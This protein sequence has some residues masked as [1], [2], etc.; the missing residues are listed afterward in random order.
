MAGIPYSD[1]D[2]ELATLGALLT[3]SKDRLVEW[4]DKLTED[5]FTRPQYKIIYRAVM[6]VYSSGFIVELQSVAGWL[7]ENGL[8]EKAGGLMALTSASGA[9]GNLPYYG[10]RLMELTERRRMAAAL[11]QMG[12]CLAAGKLTT[13][14][15]VSLLSSA[16]TERKAGGLKNICDILSEGALDNLLSDTGGRGISTGFAFLDDL[17]GGFKP[18]QMIILAARPAMGKSALASQVALNVARAGGNV[19]FFS[20]EMTQAEIAARLVSQ[21]GGLNIKTAGAE[22][23]TGGADKLFELSGKLDIMDASKARLTVDAIRLELI[24]RKAQGW[25]P[26]LVVIDYLGLLGVNTDKAASEYLRITEISRSLKQLAVETACPFLVLAQLNRQSESRAAGVKKSAGYDGLAPLKPRLSD[27]RD[28]GALEQDADIVA[29]LFRAGYYLKDKA[30]K[31]AEL[32]LLKV[33]N[34]QTGTVPMYFCGETVSFQDMPAGTIW[35]YAAGSWVEQSAID[36][37][38]RLKINSEGV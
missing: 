22:N 32:L 16:S 17:I 29:G 1:T 26:S 21:A 35:G 24:K 37:A 27:L 25:T 31:T 13:E 8:T 19:A 15:A 9:A 18:G 6:A 20:L 33:R 5:D 2:T 30:D 36:S 7:H 10:K 23:I 3:C 38:K 28:S 11:S 34:G 12:E 4:L 14:K